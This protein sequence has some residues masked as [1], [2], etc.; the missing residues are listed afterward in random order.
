MLP[1][2]AAYNQACGVL[3]RKYQPMKITQRESSWG[4]QQCLHFNMQDGCGTISF[5][6]YRALAFKPGPLTSEARQSVTLT[7]L[8]E[9]NVI[10]STVSPSLIPASLLEQRPESALIPIIHTEKQPRPSS[11][12]ISKSPFNPSLPVSSLTSDFKKILV[13]ISPANSFSEIK[14]KRRINRTQQSEVLTSTPYKDQLE[15]K[16]TWLKRKYRR[17]AERELRRNEE[18]K[19]RARNEPNPKDVTPECITYRESFEEDWVQCIKCRGWEHF[20]AQPDMSFGWG[21]GGDSP[22]PDSH[23]GG[24]SHRCVTRP[25]TG[26]TDS[27]RALTPLPR[28]AGGVDDLRTCARTF[29]LIP[30]SDTYNI[31]TAAA[32]RLAFC[33]IPLACLACSNCLAKHCVIEGL[34]RK[35]LA[36]NYSVR[37]RERER[38]RESAVDKCECA[39]IRNESARVPRRA[40]N[41]TSSSL[42]R[43][44]KDFPHWASAPRRVFRRIHTNC[45]AVDTLPLPP[46]LY[47]WT[48][49][50]CDNPPPPPPS[51]PEKLPHS[52]VFQSHT[53]CIPF[54]AISRTRFTS[55]RNAFPAMSSLVSLDTHILC[56]KNR[57]KHGLRY[58]VNT[59]VDFLS[60]L[61]VVPNGI[62]PN[63]VVTDG[64]MSNDRKPR[65]IVSNVRETNAIVSISRTPN[66]IVSTSGV[67]DVIVPSSKV[68]NVVMPN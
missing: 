18:V 60:K 54:H 30:H 23:P 22:R 6:M 35:G 52:A 38:E 48:W 14:V 5:C 64:I 25:A 20:H 2:K 43:G 26:M 28:P 8:I 29:Q 36:A 45:I 10:D 11:A 68:L 57:A 42:L 67:S 34:W 41:D 40:R 61:N 55:H 15:E 32:G 66:G 31:N 44:I 19:K 65:G 17:E 7:S 49:L 39:T 9:S 37:E 63:I 13:N 53:G 21:E 24:L 46:F 51:V 1:F 56:S 50:N 58:L 27:L 33:D 59:S 4:S 16:R 3:M 62:M 47:S 12:H